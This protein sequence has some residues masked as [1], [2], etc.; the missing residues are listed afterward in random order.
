M[1]EFD[2][3]SYHV[4][5]CVGHDVEVVYLVGNKYYIS[6][7]YSDFFLFFCLLHIFV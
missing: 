4:C 1:C 3:S 2:S 5:V 6:M 7:F